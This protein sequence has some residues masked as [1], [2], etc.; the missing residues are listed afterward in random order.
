MARGAE[1]EAVPG[2]HLHGLL[3]PRHR[4]LDL[5][6]TPRTHFLMVSTS[7]LMLL[8]LSQMFQYIS[9]SRLMLFSLTLWAT[10]S[11]KLS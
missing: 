3:L 7:W 8:W 6:R 4:L 2:L 5:Q 11:R 1:D 9:D 10:L